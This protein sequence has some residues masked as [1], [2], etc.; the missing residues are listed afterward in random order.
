MPRIGRR[1]CAVAAL[2]RGIAMP[3]LGGPWWHR[4]HAVIRQRNRD[5]FSLIELLVV[6]ALIALLIAVVLPALGLARAEARRASCAASLGQLGE[7]SLAFANDH[8]GSLFE[9]NRA[10]TTTSGGG[11][12]GG[13]TQWWFGFE[14]ANMLTTHRP[15]D[16]KR[17]PLAE[18]TGDLAAAL[19][20]AVFPYDDPAFFPKFDRPVKSYGYNWRLSGL[21][22]IGTL[23]MPADDVAPLSLGQIASGGSRVFLFADGV[24]FDRPDSF[25]EPH[26][27]AYTPNVNVLSGYAH[28]RHRGQAQAVFLD[29][30]VEAVTLQGASHRTVADAATGNLGDE[31]LYGR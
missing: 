6:I 13:G 30:H 4:R 25:N 3:R 10:D 2:I 16:Q 23:E 1:L 9:Y 21:R 12:G 26:Y 7:A 20:C 28:F 15:I 8:D 19:R 18:Y 14:P 27:I 24:H 31:A 29:A 11:A 17:G 22:R 5:A